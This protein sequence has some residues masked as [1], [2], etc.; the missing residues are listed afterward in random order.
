MRRR[1]SAPRMPS[2]ASY[3]R[4]GVPCVRLTSGTGVGVVVLSPDGVEDPIVGPGSR[5]CGYPRRGQADAGA[6]SSRPAGVTPNPHSERPGEAGMPPPGQRPAPPNGAWKEFR[7]SSPPP[8]RPDPHSLGSPAAG[9]TAV[10]AR[11]LATTRGG[12]TVKHLDL[13]TASAPLGTCTFAR[14]PC[15]AG[16]DLPPAGGWTSPE[17]VA[18]TGPPSGSGGCG[19]RDAGRWRVPAPDTGHVADHADDGPGEAHRADAARAA[20]GRYP[21][22]RGQRVDLCRLWGAGALRPAG[23][24]VRRRG[25]DDGGAGGVLPRPRDGSPLCRD[26]GGLAVEPVELPVVVC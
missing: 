24:G 23:D 3:V 17:V 21:V 6:R 22:C 20:A 4:G 10:A 7:R 9:S 8:S 15:A 11:A 18:S 12:L 5:G 1:A 25:R 13:P 26:V 16:V 19:A 14:G 2:R